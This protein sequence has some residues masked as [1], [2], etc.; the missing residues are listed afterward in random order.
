M[1]LSRVTRLTNKQANVAILVVG[2]E[3]EGRV[4]ADEWAAVVRREDVRATEKEKVVIGESFRVGDVVRGVVVCLPISISTVGLREDGGLL[5]GI[6]GDWQ[7][8]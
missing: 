7:G 6:L 8:T 5:K 3:E 1:V 2:D 4:C